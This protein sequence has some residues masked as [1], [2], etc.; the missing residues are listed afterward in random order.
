MVSGW[1][2]RDWRLVAFEVLVKVGETLQEVELSSIL[3]VS[4]PGVAPSNLVHCE[5]AS[6]DVMVWRSEIFRAD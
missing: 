4:F 6:P 1:E 3:R 2:I 5:V